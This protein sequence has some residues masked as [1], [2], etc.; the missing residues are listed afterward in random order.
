[1]HR[2]RL[3]LSF[4]DGLGPPTIAHRAAEGEMPACRPQAILDASLVQNSRVF[5]QAGSPTVALPP[6]ELLR[7]NIR[8]AKLS[9]QVLTADE[10]AIE[11][12]VDLV[13]RF[14]AEEGFSGNR[15]GIAA[16]T[17]RMIADPFHWIGLAR[18]DDTAVG[19]VTVTTMLYIEWG[20]L[21]EIGDLYVL[22]E[23]RGSGIGAALIEAAIEQC[24][25]LGCSAVS[26]T[27]TREGDAKHGLTRFYERFGFTSSGRSLATCILG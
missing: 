4:S 20:R 25:A 10:A 18:A 19:V 21:G 26:V 16:N 15:S 1:M 5:I 11:S 3:K 22:P 7:H 23:M 27:I 13:S 6:N 12:V 8:M 9:C 2:G 17:R 24:R 14:F